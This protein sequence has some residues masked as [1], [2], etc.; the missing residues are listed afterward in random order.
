MVKYELILCKISKFSYQCIVTFSLEFL[1]Q[2]LFT[3]F[4]LSPSINVYDIAFLDFQCPQGF[5]KCYSPV[6][7]PRNWTESRK[8]CEEKNASLTVINNKAQNKFIKELFDKSEN[9]SVLDLWIGLY[10]KQHKTLSHSGVPHKNHFKWVD[11]TEVSC[12][13]SYKKS[14]KD[15]PFN[16]LGTFC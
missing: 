3:I 2:L 8:Q 14:V 6:Q 16:I 7:N 5:D 11:G 9:P 13:I 4:L 15:G 10:D 12:S 1:K